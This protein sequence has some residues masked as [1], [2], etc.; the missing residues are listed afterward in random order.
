MDNKDKFAFTCETIAAVAGLVGMVYCIKAYKAINNEK[1][2]DEAYDAA[3]MYF[4]FKN[5][6]PNIQK[7]SDQTNN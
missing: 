5:S 6:N 4:K 1:I 7:E 3:E 2:F